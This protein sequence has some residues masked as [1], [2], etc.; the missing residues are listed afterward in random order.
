M[1]KKISQIMH[2]LAT[3]LNWDPTGRYIAVSVQGNSD[4]TG[5]NIYNVR[6][7]VLYESPLMTNLSSFA[8][9]PMPPSL[10]TDK[11]QHDLVG[12]E[13]KWKQIEKKYDALDSATQTH[14]ARTKF[15]S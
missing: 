10:L 15:V 1:Q 7:D 4:A 5:Y 3:S 12:T 6:G 14:A 8:W 2:P 13:A 11:E 9:R